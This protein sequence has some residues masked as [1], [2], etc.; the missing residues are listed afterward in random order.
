[1]DLNLLLDL[2]D[3][4]VRNIGLVA[5]D[6]LDKLLEGRAPSLDVHEVHE[7]EFGKDPALRRL[8]LATSRYNKAAGDQRL[9]V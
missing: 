6:D 2:A 7:D 1:M 8:Q 9:T 5:I 4:E 3:I